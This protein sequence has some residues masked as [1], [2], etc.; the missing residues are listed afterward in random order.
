MMGESPSL[1]A[2]LNACPEVEVAPDI[3]PFVFTTETCTVPVV[4]QSTCSTATA[5]LCSGMP[6]SPA[7]AESCCERTRM[8]SDHSGPGWRGMAL[9]L[10]T[11]AGLASL[12]PGADMGGPQKFW[13]ERLSFQRSHI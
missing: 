9:W 11:G 12:P 13:L 2:I 1:P 10:R 8:I 6:R 3:S 7:I 5:R 4:G